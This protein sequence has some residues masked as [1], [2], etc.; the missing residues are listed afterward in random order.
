MIRRRRD[1]KQFQLSL[2]QEFLFMQQKEI[3]DEEWEK[4]GYSSYNAYGCCV[5]EGWYDIL[6]GLCLDITK[7]Y[8]TAN[9]PVD[10][11]VDQVKQKF[12]T[13]RFYWHPA[14]HD[15]GIHAFDFLGTGTL[16]ISPGKTDLHQEISKIVKKWE[17]E[18]GKTCEKCG[19]SGELRN[20]LGWVRTYCD[21]CYTEEME[22]LT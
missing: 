9:V 20:K 8:E 15:P 12:G 6:R 10:L 17:E 3:S 13:L 4:G 18:S 5:G 14:G 1:K 22:D 7:A 21:S 19:A 11:V 2:E 16:R